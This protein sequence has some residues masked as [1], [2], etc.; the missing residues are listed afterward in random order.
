MTL[1]FTRLADALVSISTRSFTPSRPTLSLLCLVYGLIFLSLLLLFSA[2]KGAVTKFEGIFIKQ[3][4]WVILG[5]VAYVFVR[6]ID[7]RNYRPDRKFDFVAT[8]VSI[9]GKLW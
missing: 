4:A 5:T 6:N 9:A 7:Y 8:E 1:P 2:S 3:C